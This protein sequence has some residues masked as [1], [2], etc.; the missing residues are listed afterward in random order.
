MSEMRSVISIY[1]ILRNNKDNASRIMYQFHSTR[2]DT[3]DCRKGACVY[4]HKMR[5]TQRQIDVKIYAEVLAYCDFTFNGTSDRNS[6]KLALHDSCLSINLIFELKS[7]L[8]QI[9]PPVFS[10]RTKS[11]T[12]H[13]KLGSLLKSPRRIQDGET[14]D[15]DFQR[16]SSSRLHPV[17][18]VRL[19]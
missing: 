16:F 11:D 8:R 1:L 10:V 18:S 15:C 3:V 12:I 2:F 7:T 5:K 19:C 14:S 17:Y 13:I 6:N 4:T 9:V